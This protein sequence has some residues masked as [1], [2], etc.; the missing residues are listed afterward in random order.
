MEG[1]KGGAEASDYSVVFLPWGPGYDAKKCVRL[2]EAKDELLNNSHLNKGREYNLH[3]CFIGTAEKIL[4]DCSPDDPAIPEDADQEQLKG[5]VRGPLKFIE[6]DPGRQMIGSFHPITDTDWVAGA[7]ISEDTEQLCVAANSNDLTK[8]QKMLQAGVDVN[9]TDYAG[10][11]ALHIA[12]LT[13]SVECAGALIEGGAKICHRMPDGRNSL[14]IASAYGHSKIVEMLLQKHKQNEKLAE[15]ADKE[16]QPSMDVDEQDEFVDVTNSDGEEGDEDEVQKKDWDVLDLEGCDWAHRMTALHYAITFGHVEVVKQLL[17]VGCDAMKGWIVGEDKLQRHVIAPLTLISRVFMWLPNAADQILQLMITHG[18]AATKLDLNLNSVL[19][20]AAQ[21]GNHRFLASVMKHAP[22]VTKCLNVINTASQTPLLTA[23]HCQS[24]ECVRL[25]LDAGAGAN[26]SAEDCDLARRRFNSIKDKR[27]SDYRLRNLVKITTDD[28]ESPLMVAVKKAM[29]ISDDEDLGILDATEEDAATAAKTLAKNP[30]LKDPLII[31]KMLVDHGADVNCIK[32]QLTHS[33]SFSH[34]WRNQSQ[35]G[36]KSTV[37][38]FVVQQIE[39]QEKLVKTDKNEIQKALGESIEDFAQRLSIVKVTK[40][41]GKDRPDRVHMKVGQLLQDLQNKYKDSYLMSTVEAVALQDDFRYL[42]G[43]GLIQFEAQ[44]GWGKQAKLKLARALKKYLQSKHAKTF[45]EIDSKAAKKQEEEK[46]KEQQYNRGWVGSSTYYRNN[47][48]QSIVNIFNGFPNIENVWSRLITYSLLPDYSQSGYSLDADSQ[49]LS[50]KQQQDSHVLFESVW[51]N[52]QRMVEECL[53]K[54]GEDTVYVAVKNNKLTTTPF[55][56]AVLQSNKMM[57]DFLL[58]YCIKQFEPESKH[59]Q[60]GAKW[61]ELDEQEDVRIG[62]YALQYAL[63]SGYYDEE[64]WDENSED[65]SDDDNDDEYGQFDDMV[66]EMRAAKEAELEKEQ[67]LIDADEGI[68]IEQVEAVDVST[69][70][71]VLPHKFYLT[72]TTVPIFAVQQGDDKREFEESLTKLWQA[73]VSNDEQQFKEIRKGG[74]HTINQ[75]NGCP[76]FWVPLYPLQVAMFRGDMPMIQHIMESALMMDGLVKEQLGALKPPQAETPE[77]QKKGEGE[78]EDE[79]D[80]DVVDKRKLDPMSFAR[81]VAITSGAFQFAIKK[82]NVLMLE[83]FCKL[84]GVEN[85]PNMVKKLETDMRN[86]TKQ[87]KRWHKTAQVK[88]EINFPA[89]ILGIAVSA[90]AKQVIEWIL[91]GNCK[92]V[93]MELCDKYPT[94]KAACTRLAELLKEFSGFVCN[95]ED[96]FEIIDEL[97]YVGV[98]KKKIESDSDSNNYY[99]NN[100]SVSQFIS[101]LFEIGNST[102]MIE[103]FVEKCRQ[104]GYGDY[105]EYSLQQPG[106]FIQ[107]ASCNNPKLLSL[108]LDWGLDPCQVEKSERG[109]NILAILASNYNQKS[110]EED[111]ELGKSLFKAVLQHEKV[112]DAQRW[113]LLT[114]KMGK[115]KQ[116]L[117]SVFAHANLTKTNKEDMLQYVLSIIPPEMFAYRNLDGYT[118]LHEA[119]KNTKL[120]LTERII[121]KEAQVVDKGSMLCCNIE[122]NVGFT[123]MDISM[124]HLCKAAGVQSMVGNFRKRNFN[125]EESSSSEE[126]EEE[127]EEET[128]DYQQQSLD[129]PVSRIYKKVK[130]AVTDKKSRRYPTFEEVQESRTI[131]VDEAN[132]EEVEFTR[133]KPDKPEVVTRWVSC[134]YHNIFQG[135]V[136]SDLK[137]MATNLQL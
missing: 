35:T 63:M 62:N 121:D 65:C 1:F 128:D 104:Y 48:L 122:D 96:T 2:M 115:Y 6:D 124:N 57:M 82:D 16:K 39:E 44:K 110:K 136:Q 80:E 123:P 129:S 134:H 87:V 58:K 21:E 127:E 23:V 88:F 126:N 11:S 90:K 67:E 50:N 45:K 24:V 61:A 98:R 56:L 10:R 46:N 120:E 130:S 74:V 117:L 20:T 34:N 86:Q 49:L 53:A 119:T 22:D 70:T 19:H 25:L 51:K 102:E 84:L 64:C 137:S 135:S 76:S 131:A 42:F 77:G 125:N 54:Q 89:P 3:P 32:Q 94:Y 83:Y 4:Q 78:A 60:I 95:S 103:W 15:I 114:M 13:N 8:L 38:D 113:Q 7:Y 68:A 97:L 93:L 17:A 99:G 40:S 81:K 92:R 69:T 37:L 133:N 31:V 14:H 26:I 85:Y 36:H 29:E 18:C 106:L 112:T 43:L 55:M 27:K 109:W 73:I 12:T 75:N 59:R 79:G 47:V 9:L 118:V 30:K 132:T 105:V 101:S 52:D 5:F 66:E 108:L 33:Y 100:Y 71:H 116:S 72:Q 107:A 91:S 28:I 111:V 41:S